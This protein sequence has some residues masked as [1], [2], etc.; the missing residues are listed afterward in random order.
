MR[1]NVSCIKFM[2]WKWPWSLQ[3]VG[4]LQIR[5]I[6]LQGHELWNQIVVA[7]WTVWVTHT[8]AH[9]KDLFADKTNLYQALNSVYIVNYQ[10][11]A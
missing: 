9:R 7:D 4:L 6:Y 2:I 11:A 8:D 10:I 1:R 3:S 5:D